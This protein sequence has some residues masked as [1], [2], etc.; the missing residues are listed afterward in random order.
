MA[1]YLA[2]GVEARF[3]AV[4]E[5]TY[6]TLVTIAGT[7]AMPL[8]DMK[9]TPTRDYTKSKERTGTASLRHEIPGKKGGTW[10]A[11]FYAKVGAAATTAPDCG[12][13]MLAAFGDENTTTD[14]SYRMHDGTNEVTAP[15]TLQLVRHAGKGI[16]EIANGA[17]VEQVDI[18]ATGN[19]EA[20]ISVSGG[21]AS[22]GW[23][24]GALVEGSHAA[25]DTTIEVEAGTAERVGVNSLVQF[26]KTD[27]TVYDNSSAGYKVTAVNGSTD[28]VTISPA[29][30]VGSSLDDAAEMLPFTPDQ[31]LDTK[32]PLEVTGAAL[33]IGSNS[34]MGFISGKVSM[35]TGIHGLDK[36]GTSTTSTRISR[37]AR[38]VTG[39]IQ[40]Y[41]IASGAAGEDVS[42]YAGD[43]WNGTVQAITLRIG[44]AASDRMVINIPAARIEVSEVEIPEAEE[45]TVNFS[46]VARKSSSD[47][48]ELSVDFIQ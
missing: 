25:A 1:T 32:T 3:Y 37:G 22:F 40:A 43:A 5:T 30:E 48:D 19:E 11:S 20:I 34:G 8:I 16:M 12:D 27:G 26:I 47:G 35:A 28:I 21:F 38:E 23:C 45:A 42:R 44:P 46:F 2:A 6:N 33:T 14:V 17:W 36:E 29:L 9:L 24:Y 13:L 10:S 4:K 39:E 15:T 41:F 7:H 18:E 31:T